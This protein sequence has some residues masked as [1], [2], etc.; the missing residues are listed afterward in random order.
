MLI[1]DE[2]DC[3]TVTPLLTSLDEQGSSPV[4]TPP[5]LPVVWHELT[6]SFR[7]WDVPW[8]WGWATVRNDLFGQFSY[9]HLFYMLFKKLA[10]P[11]FHIHRFSSLYFCCRA[12]LRLVM[13]IER[14]LTMASQC[15]PEKSTLLPR[16]P[17]NC[18]WFYG[19]GISPYMITGL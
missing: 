19:S 15:I 5:F 11:S 3:D 2:F 12:I 7:S 6:S 4:S 16:C 13:G 18:K 1:L 8:I 10:V 14:L 9:T 17:R